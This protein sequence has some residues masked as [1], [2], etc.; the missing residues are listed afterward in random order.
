[1]NRC[2]SLLTAVAGLLVAMSVSAAPLHKCTV[3]GAVTYQQGACASD[4]PRKTPTIQELNAETK[5]KRDAAASAPVDRAVPVSPPAVSGFS[6]DGRK[7]CSQ[8]KS[9]AEAKYFLANCPGTTMDG[10]KNGIPC[11]KQWCSR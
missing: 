10:D 6:C 3:N 7:V 1:M 2:T 5:K 11:E 8:M 9:C 4:Q